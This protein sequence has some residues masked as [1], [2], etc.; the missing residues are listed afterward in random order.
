MCLIVSAREKG[1]SLTMEKALEKKV[2]RSN[3]LCQPQR[4]KVF[5]S[6]NKCRRALVL[7]YIGLGSKLRLPSWNGFGQV[8]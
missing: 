3:W 8:I 2:N 4:R 7:K 1:T 5:Y 6:I